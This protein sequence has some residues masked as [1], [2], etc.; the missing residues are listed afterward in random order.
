MPVTLLGFGDPLF[1]KVHIVPAPL[2]YVICAC[3][4]FTLH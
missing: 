4:K 2:G 1:N 3:G